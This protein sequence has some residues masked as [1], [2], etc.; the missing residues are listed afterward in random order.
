MSWLITI[1]ILLVIGFDL[2]FEL[3]LYTNLARWIQNALTAIKNQHIRFA[4]QRDRKPTLA[5]I[6]K[7]MEKRAK[8]RFRD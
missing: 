1:T 3:Q 6:R 2:L 7:E 5:R 8:H 4:T